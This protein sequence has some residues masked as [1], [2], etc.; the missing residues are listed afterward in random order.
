MVDGHANLHVSMRT[1]RT[2]V[3]EHKTVRTVRIVRMILYQSIK[4]TNFR[5]FLIQI[6]FGL[7]LSS[8][9]FY[10]WVQACTFWLGLGSGLT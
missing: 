8:S 10:F 3:H 2:T 5:T 4:V 9:R 7:V 6:N 1:A